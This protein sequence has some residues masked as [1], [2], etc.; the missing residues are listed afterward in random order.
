MLL[1]ET[2]SLRVNLPFYASEQFAPNLAIS[3][4]NFWI[5]TNENGLTKSNI[6]PLVDAAHSFPEYCR[7]DFELV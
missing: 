7:V 2:I 5:Y 4:L 3:P 1:E 6:R